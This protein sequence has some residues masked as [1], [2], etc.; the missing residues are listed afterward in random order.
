[1]IIMMRSAMV[2]DAEVNSHGVALLREDICSVQQGAATIYPIFWSLNINQEQ[3]IVDELKVSLLRRASPV[4][5]RLSG[6]S[7]MMLVHPA[8]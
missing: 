6:I 8:P 3:L 7:P 1:M 5:S 4:S 2:H